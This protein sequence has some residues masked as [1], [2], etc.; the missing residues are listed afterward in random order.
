[1]GSGFVWL[2]GHLLRAPQQRAAHGPPLDVHTNAHFFN[3]TCRRQLS[4]LAH[5]WTA[6]IIDRAFLQSQHIVNDYVFFRS[7]IDKAFVQSTNMDDDDNVFIG[8]SIKW[9]LYVRSVYIN[10]D[11]QIVVQGRDPNG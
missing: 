5:Q 3:A 6:H 1:V 2:G 11:A 9:N 10:N 7:L 8:A 4:A